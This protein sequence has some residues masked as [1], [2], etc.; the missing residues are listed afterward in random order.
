MP[1]STLTLVSCDVDRC[2][3]G[4][5]LGPGD[6]DSG[7][8]LHFAGDRDDAAAAHDD[9]AIVHGVTALLQS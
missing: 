5:S 7:I 4:A 9:V 8:A 3:N 1:H 6:D 2:C